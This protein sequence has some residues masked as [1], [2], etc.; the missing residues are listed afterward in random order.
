MT[1]LYSYMDKSYVLITYLMPD[2]IY[3]VFLLMVTVDA[4]LLLDFYFA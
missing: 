2:P 4:G 3:C 1:T